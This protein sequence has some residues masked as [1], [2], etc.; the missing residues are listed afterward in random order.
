MLWVQAE[1][2]TSAKNLR[3]TKAAE[4][5]V[6]RER[7]ALKAHG[8]RTFRE[9]VAAR[10]GPPTRDAYLTLARV[11]YEDAQEAWERLQDEIEFATPTLIIDLTDGEPRHLN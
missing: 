6:N 4:A 7:D 1:M 11:E 5:A 10:L 3:K 9:Y 2:L 8:Y